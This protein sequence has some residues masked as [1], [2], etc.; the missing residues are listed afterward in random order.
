MSHS[1]IPGFYKFSVADRLQLLF[2]RG[3]IG[4]AEYHMLMD[5]A[6]VMNADTADRLVENVIGTF[7]LPMG[8]GLNF[9]INA[10]DYL[11]P[12]VVEEPSI[13]AAVSAAAKLV[14][15]A[16][17]FDSHADDPL[18]IGQIQVVGLTHAAQAQQAL[19]QAREEILNLAN[20]L[21]PNMV[22]RGGGARDL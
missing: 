9:R 1:R 2:E 5:G 7:S 4:E 19:L 17:G 6:Q 11:V 12:M 22:A 14:R 3:V 13:I 15:N 16:G 18:L 21:H 10:Q 8:L 20:S